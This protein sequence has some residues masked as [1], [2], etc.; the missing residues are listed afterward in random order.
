MAAEVGLLTRNIKIIGE[1]YTQQ[2]DEAFGAR[3]LVGSFTEDGETYTGNCK[4]VT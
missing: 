4:R 3:M 1:E 2:L